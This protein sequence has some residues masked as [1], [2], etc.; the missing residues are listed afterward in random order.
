MGSV[1]FEL[2]LAYRCCHKNF[3][4]EE[5]CAGLSYRICTVQDTILSHWGLLKTLLTTFIISKYFFQTFVILTKSQSLPWEFHILVPRI[6]ETLKIIKRS[7]IYFKIFCSGVVYFYIWAFGQLPNDMKKADFFVRAVSR[8]EEHC[9]TFFMRLHYSGEKRKKPFSHFE[10]LM[11][12][13]SAIAYHLG[14]NELII[15]LQRIKSLDYTFYEL[16]ILRT[17]QQ[18]SVISSFKSRKLIMELWSVT[19]LNTPYLP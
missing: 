4:N 2:L 18:R 19:Y 1:D 13:K 3:E 10:S 9:S 15:G 6:Q 16:E 12:Y 8:F 7:G 17:R 14:H 5:H 11:F